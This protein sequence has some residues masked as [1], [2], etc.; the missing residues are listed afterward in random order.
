M[1]KATKKTTKRTK[2]ADTAAAATALPSFRAK[3][4]ALPLADKIKVARAVNGGLRRAGF[5]G[6]GGYRTVHG[7]DQMNRPR[8]SAETEGEI[9]QLTISERNRLIALARNAARN[10]DRLEGIL[11]QLEINV[12]GV[13]GGKAIFEFPPEFSEAGETIKREFANWAQEAEYFEDHDLQDTIKLALRTQMLGGD[14]VFV[15]DDDITGGSTGQIIAFEPDCIGDL[16]G[17]ERRFRGFRQYQGIVKNANGKTV[18]VTV[19]WSQRGR[20]EYDERD[21]DGNLGAWTLIK[22][23]GMRW[24]DS[25]FMIFRG[26]GRFNQI[27]GNSRLWPGL[28][29]VADLVDFQGFEVQAAKSG[30]QKIGQILQ[31]EEQNKGDLAGELDPDATAPIGG[32]KLDAAIADGEIE[33]DDREQLDVEAIS[34]AGVIWDLLPPGVKMELFDTKHPNDKL[35]EFMNSL[36]GAVAFAIGLGKANATGE[37]AQSY[38]ASLVELMLSQIE[39]DDEFHKLEKGFL[40]WVLARWSAWAQR[41]GLIPDDSRLPVDWRRTCVKW[42]RPPRRVIDPVKEQNALA[43]GLKNGT[44]LYRDKWGADWRGKLD[45]LCEEIE[46]FKAKGVPHPALFTV[47]GTEINNTNADDGEKE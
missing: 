46:A 44:I 29:T 5:F 30:A 27:R 2:G 17:F 22:P 35:V 37:A 21:A 11:H 1:A 16:V 33:G 40:D 24:K 34:G 42:S 19:S 7:P 41:R 32:D 39:F 14:C 43:L 23:E 6:R 31:A 28:G 15:F 38:S 26:S 13:E 9:G 36:H 25:P 47:S 45:A 4:A 20:A 3:F 8:I 12:V 10:S 18:G